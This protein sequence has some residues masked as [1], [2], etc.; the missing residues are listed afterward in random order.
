LE[1]AR[2]TEHTGTA[3]RVHTIPGMAQTTNRARLP[4]AKV[5]RAGGAVTR[6]WQGKDSSCSSIQGSWDFTSSS[7]P[8][9][10]EGRTW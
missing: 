4:L 2:D 6:P 5:P 8:G 7:S 1:A 9:N 10:S 3:V